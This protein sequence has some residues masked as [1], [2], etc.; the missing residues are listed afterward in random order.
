MQAIVNVS[1]DGMIGAQTSKGGHWAQLLRSNGEM[2]QATMSRWVSEQLSSPRRVIWEINYELA[3]CLLILE[4]LADHEGFPGLPTSLFSELVH[5][6]PELKDNQYRKL[7]DGQGNTIEGSG[8]SVQAKD[9]SEAKEAAQRDRVWQNQIT[10]GRVPHI[11][12]AAAVGTGSYVALV[13]NYTQGKT[14]YASWDGKK[15][16]LDLPEWVNREALK[17]LLLANNCKLVMI[18]PDHWEYTL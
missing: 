7:L 9:G 13:H 8:Q 18:S 12:V 3:K 15:Y 17:K 1:E 16:V 14:L 10:P 5:M 11:A 2:I 6:F 4:G